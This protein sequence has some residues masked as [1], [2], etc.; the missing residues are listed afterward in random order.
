[1]ELKNFFSQDDAG[2][3]LGAATCYLYVRGTENLVSGLVKAN[4][5]D[6]TNPFATDADGLAQFAAPNGLYDLRVVKGARDYRLRLQFNDVAETVLAAESAASRAETARDTFNLNVGRKAD[7]ATGL[8]ETIPGQSFTVLAPNA[9]D[10]IIEYENNAGVAVEKKRYPSS[11]SV[12]RVN[13]MLGQHEQVSVLAVLDP[14]GFV[15][16]DATPDKIETKNWSLSTEGVRFGSQ[17]IVQTE[18][19][20]FGLIDELGYVG[21]EVGND[22]RVGGAPSADLDPEV[23]EGAALIADLNQR[24]LISAYAI[25]SRYNAEVARPRW[26]YNHFIAYGQS[27]SNGQEGWPA[28]SKSAR[29]GNVML[30]DATRPLQGFSTAFDPVGGT[31]QF[32]PLV[33][34]V[35]SVGNGSIMT[36]AQVAELAPGAQNYGEDPLVGMLNFAKLQHNQRSMVANDGSRTFLGSACGASGLT[37]EY[38][39]K[40][41]S[42]DLYQR[43]VGAATAAKAVATAEGKSY[44]VAA[45]TWLQGESNYARDEDTKEGYKALL[46]TL[47]SNMIVDLKGISGQSETPLFISYQTGASYTS[48]AHGLAIGMA[49]L[50][51]SEERRNWVLATPVYPYTDKAGHLDANGYRWVGKQ[52]AKVWHRVVELGQDWKPLSPIEIIRSGK[53]ILIGFHVPCPPLV[54]GKPY[55]LTTATDYAN[56]G[57][58]VLVGGSPVAIAKVEIVAD[59]VVRIALASEPAGVIEVRYAGKAAH[60]GN[61]CL[62]DSDPTVADDN[63][64][65]TAGTGQYESANIPELVGKPYPLHNWCVA[66]QRPTTE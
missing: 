4:G 20:A 27:L 62:R 13:S 11:E 47:Y 63:Y 8:L 26:D 28:L 9:D 55:V 39:S 35:Q 31:A 46:A 58:E 43:I 3:M 53:D 59:C 16:L 25:V 37:I 61:G 22:G 21:Y 32:K 60:N 7:V 34:V 36:A 23:V 15:V 14:D 56:K 24:A 48:D 17:A 29:H 49:Q 41:A 33:A 51:L 52:F 66:F 54:F 10:F 2:N 1:M 57:F 30:G 6:L 45:I 18:D 50:E 42:P 44:G 64:E 5:T 38:L 19:C 40:G 12:S 65:Y